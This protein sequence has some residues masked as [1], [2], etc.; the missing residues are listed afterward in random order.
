MKKSW[1]Q[2]IIRVKL[3]PSAIGTNNSLTSLTKCAITIPTCLAVNQSNEYKDAHYVGNYK[4]DQYQLV[5]EDVG[6]NHW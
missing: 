1:K 4:G 5:S 6:K 3:A 2:G